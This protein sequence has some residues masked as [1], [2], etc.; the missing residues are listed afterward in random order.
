MVFEW[1]SVSKTDRFFDVSGVSPS[2]IDTRDFFDAFNKG[3][4]VHFAK[5]RFALRPD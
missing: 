5:D 4:G 1:R 2:D 3:V